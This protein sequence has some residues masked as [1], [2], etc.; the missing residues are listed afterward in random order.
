MCHPAVLLHF[1][2]LKKPSERSFLELP[3]HVLGKRCLPRPPSFPC[4]EK[5][6]ETVLREATEPMEGPVG[7]LHASV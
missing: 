5:L 7:A 2:G 4:Q 3:W 6:S 1:W